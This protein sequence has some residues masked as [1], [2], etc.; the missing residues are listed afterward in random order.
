MSVECPQC[1][2]LN[3]DTAVTCPCG[4][5]L[6]PRLRGSLYG[7]TI[8]DSAHLTKMWVEGMSHG[9]FVLGV[10]ATF[11]VLILGEWVS[12]RLTSRRP[13]MAILWESFKFATTDLIGALMVGSIS[14]VVVWVLLAYEGAGWRLCPKRITLITTMIA[15][16]FFSLVRWGNPFVIAES[17]TGLI[18]LAVAIAAYFAGSR[19]WLGRW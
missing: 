1:H 6:H 9:R 4:Y 3:S 16:V 8:Q 11:L 10:G 14:W 12:L 5:D 18:T 17:V 7:R 15:A 2:K 13:S 19:G